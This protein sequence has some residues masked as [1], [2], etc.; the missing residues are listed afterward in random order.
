MDID[1]LRDSW[2]NSDDLLSLYFFYFYKKQKTPLESESAM[3][4]DGDKFK[5]DFHI[6]GGFLV[7]LGGFSF[8]DKMYTEKFNHQ[9]EG[10]KC[11]GK[12]SKNL[13][14]VKEMF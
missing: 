6:F 5:E 4:L 9:S 3:N 14:N 13:A 12:C 1:V 2:K 11:Q 8:G 10:S 7:G